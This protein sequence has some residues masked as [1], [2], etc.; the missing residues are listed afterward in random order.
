MAEFKIDKGSTP[1]KMSRQGWIPDLVVSHITEGNYAGAVSWLSSSKSRAS[2]HFVVAQDGKITQLVDISEA[3]WI[4]GT[5]TDPTK[6]NFYGNSLL[7]SVRDR[8]TNA[9]F[10]S[11]G[12][13]HEGIHAKTKGKLT[14]RQLEATVWLHKHIIA[15]IKRIYGTD[16]ILDREHIVGHY[17]VDPKRKPFCPGELFQFDE[18]IDALKKEEEVEAMKLEHDWQ[19]DMLYKTVE[20]LE[21]KGILTSS[22]WKEKVKSKTLTVSEATWLNMII[23]DR[24]AQ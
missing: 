12:I 7:K 24:L 19:W 8:K 10:Y 5:D 17:Q 9:N 16:I 3:A 1:N 14:D 22:E 4:N 20:S 13:E 18:I 21:K 6:A 23:L 2:S 11:V 15:E